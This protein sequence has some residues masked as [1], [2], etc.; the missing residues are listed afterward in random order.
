MKL[1][2]YICTV[3][4]LSVSFTYEE[5]KIIMKIKTLLLILRPLYMFSF[6]NKYIF[7]NCA[8]VWSARKCKIVDLGH[9]GENI[10]IVEQE[11]RKYKIKILQHKH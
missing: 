4:T 3:L 1:A 7:R 6:L 8:K 2:W 11:K 9:G 10:E 5:I